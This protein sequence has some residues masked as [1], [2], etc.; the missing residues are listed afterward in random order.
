M[1]YAEILHRCFRCG[2]CK[3]PGNYVDFNCPPYQAFRFETYSPGGRMWLLRAWLESKIELTD[4]LQ[5]IIFSCVSCGNCVEHCT[6]PKFKDQLLLAF[7]AAKAELVNGGRVP[8]AIRDCLTR[9]TQSGNFYGRSPKKREQWAQGLEIERYDKQDYLFFVGDVGAFDTRGQEIA[10]SVVR[11]LKQNGI[12]FGHL[13]A[14]EISDGNEA[15]AMGETELFRHLAE[16][17]I[18]TFNALGVQ[19]IITL[20]P[21]GF[22]VIK[23]DYPQLGGNYQVFH[24]SQILA[25]ALEKAAFRD[26]LPPLRVT[27]HDS[28]YLGR[29]NQEYGSA[30]KML[31]AVP[32]LELVEMQRGFQ[33][34]LCC[35]GGGGNVFTG[36]IDSGLDTAAR[37]RVREAVATDAQ[38]LAVACPQCAVMLADAAKVENLDRQL[39]VKELSEIVNARLAPK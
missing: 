14:A 20:S 19:Q 38:V 4:R 2:Y 21:H 37:A 26:D 35:G 24:Y 33:N 25:R 8:P 29:H 13:G 39:E 5:E 9:L 10:R 17:N 12:S 6:F 23:N 32:G 34:A 27:Y 3:L 30:R 36:I 16:K 11:C 22:H 31:S 28:C 7:T 15:H 1:Q 18:Q